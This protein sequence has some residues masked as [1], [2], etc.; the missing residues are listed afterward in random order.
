MEAQFARL[1]IEAERVE[2]VTPADLTADQR[3]RFLAHG[4]YN[5]LQPTELCCNLSHAAAL[6][7]FL[8]SGATMGALFEDDAVLADGLAD[9]LRDMDAQGPLADVL[10]LE[11]FASPVQLSHQPTSVFGDYQLHTIHGWVWGT[12]AYVVTRQAAIAFKASNV[13]E[14]TIA[15]RALFRRFPD[16]VRGITCRQLVPALAIQSDRLRGEDR[17]GSDLE[18]ERQCARNADS[19]RSVPLSHRLRR[20]WDDEIG[21]GLPATVDRLRGRSAKQIVPFAQS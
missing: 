19:A 11:T 20:F 13:L 3:E 10:R 9:L 17:S 21:V 15:D 5:R 7:R 16:R 8:A 4:S 6:D 12:A 1:G 2:A 14:Q 18:V